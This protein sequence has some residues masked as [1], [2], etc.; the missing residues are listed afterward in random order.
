MSIAN[1]EIAD[2]FMAAVSGNTSSE[3]AIGD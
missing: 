3:S 2:L 1:C